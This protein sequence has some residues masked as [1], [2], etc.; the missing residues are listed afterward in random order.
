MARTPGELFGIPEGLPD[1]GPGRVRG[2]LPADRDHVLTTVWA[3][4]TT[5]QDAWRLWAGRPKRRTRWVTGKFQSLPGLYL[6]NRELT[7]EEPYDAATAAA[8]HVGWTRW[9]RGRPG[10][11]IPRRE[12]RTPLL[13]MPTVLFLRLGPNVRYA[14]DEDAIFDWYGSYEAVLVGS[15]EEREAIHHGEGYISFPTWADAHEL[16]DLA[17][18]CE[19]AKAGDAGCRARMDAFTQ[20]FSYLAAQGYPAPIRAL[21]PFRLQLQSWA[22]DEAGIIELY[23]RLVA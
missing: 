10:P 6:Y 23:G 7:E 17:I 13:N 20:K 18:D 4:G 11:Y 1:W 15:P 22:M 5:L 21:P 12:Y 2:L 19:N 16:R 8:G 3:H 14:L 9:E